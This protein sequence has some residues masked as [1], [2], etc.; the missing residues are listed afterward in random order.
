MGGE[1]VFFFWTQMIL[2]WGVDLVFDLYKTG[3]RKVGGRMN[4]LSNGFFFTHQLTY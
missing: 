4:K 2:T 1:N 3:K